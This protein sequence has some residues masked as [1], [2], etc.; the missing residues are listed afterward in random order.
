MKTMTMY[1]VDSSIAYCE[2]KGFAKVFDAY[3]E[4]CSGEHITQIGFNPNSGYV[5][6][7]LE[8]SICIC[9]MLGQDVEYFSYNGEN[10][11]EMVAD[12]YHEAIENLNKN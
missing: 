1:D 6:I 12:T 11:D 7:H 10:D 8:S 5:Y 4:F 2:A 3:A 9:S